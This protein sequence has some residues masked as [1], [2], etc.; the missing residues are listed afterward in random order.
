[1][2]RGS[3]WKC[4]DLHIH[5]PFT[6]LNNNYSINKT[7][8]EEIEEEKIWEKYCDSLN[9]SGIDC[10]G[11]T[12]CF[13]V[14][15]FEFL[16]QNRDDFGLNEEIVLFPNV[17]L[18]VSGLISNN[19][20][21]KH[22]HVNVHLIF[23]SDIKVD[24]I[25]RF[26][27]NLTVQG[28]NGKT[29]NFLNDFEELRYKNMFTS[30]PDVET[31]RT[32]LKATFGVDYKHD[33]LIMV[34]NGG[35]GLSSDKGTGYNDNFNFMLSSVDLIQSPN[36]TDRKFYLEEAP[37]YFEK[38]FPCVTG[39][40][41]H[42]FNKI[43][44]YSKNN[45]KTWIKADPT[46][47]GL[48]SIIYEPDYRVKI[49]TGNP[50][51]MK[52]MN[53]VISHIEMPSDSFNSHK[54]YFNQD[55][56]VIIGGRSSGKSLLLSLI[57][58]KAHNIKKVK[59][60]NEEY[61]HLITTLSQDTKLYL[62]ENKE[63]NGDMIL[64]FFYQ[65][66]LQE[67]AR[68]VNKR[69]DFITDILGKDDSVSDLNQSIDSQI[70]KLDFDNL[71]AD[72]HKLN[73]INSDLESIQPLSKIQENISSF[74]DLIKTNRIEFVETEKEDLE[75]ILDEL[76]R[77]DVQNKLIE[78]KNNDL[79]ILE[80][81]EL[82][83]L[84]ENL[85]EKLDTIKEL[86]PDFQ[87]K[88]NE[89]NN[90]FQEKITQR[91]GELATYK[92]SLNKKIQEFQS[93]DIYKKHVDSIKSSPEIEEYSKKLEIEKKLLENRRDLEEEKKNRTKLIEFNN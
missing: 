33:V 93:H 90:V 81:E 6:Q 45:K 61:N 32:A 19:K 44:S 80:S 23:P 73:E 26:L 75:T 91:K 37:K 53:K 15:N 42:D 28:Q 16:S 50:S 86:F 14:S 63:I 79:E 59:G 25:K 87:E 21:S 29:L 83:I 4:W 68:D 54:I 3:E 71:I 9:K 47:E 40:D 74:E 7:K 69:N 18:R 5:T 64:E 82:F 35:D 55:L 12:D 67:I 66:K 27:S 20:D 38:Q 31:L 65:D 1:M 89:L 58:S 84:N 8:D 57:A 39:S 92:E 49:Q 30:V 85:T 46:F 76:N 88:F 56:N 10:F 78:E 77:L 52:S 43:Q 13:S 70:S 41:A 22:K 72:K 51:K 34:L 17:E 62:S 60:D 24:D 36:P 11:I 48:K 2:R